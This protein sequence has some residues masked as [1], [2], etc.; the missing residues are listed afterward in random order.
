MPTA[1][2]GNVPIRPLTAG[3]PQ[4]GTDGTPNYEK[5]TLGGAAATK[6]TL[7]TN[8]ANGKLAADSS[9]A[10]NGSQLYATNK[11]AAALQDFTNNVNNGGGIKY[12][13]SNSTLG[14]SSAT[15]T[16]SVAIGGAALSSGKNSGGTRFELG[17]GS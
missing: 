8:L 12:F 6:P 4:S 10:V 9:D 13:H 7:L 3:L 15:D 17:S 11:N 16:D 5:V 2:Q 14:D 1:P